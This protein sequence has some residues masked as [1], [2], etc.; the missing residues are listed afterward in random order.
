MSFTIDIVTRTLGRAALASC[1]GL[2][3]DAAMAQSVQGTAAYRERIA[4]PPAAVFEAAVEDV[5][6]ADAP[7]ETIAR[8][9]IMS[10]G[11]PPI[12][13]TITYDP[14]R[15]LPGQRYVVRTGI[16]VDEKLLI[17]RGSPPTVSIMLRKVGA[18]QAP[19][20]SP[21]GTRPLEGTYWRAIELTGKPTPTP[22]S[23]REAHLVF[24]AGGRVSGSDGC[25]RMTGSYERTGDVVMFGQMVG[26]QMACIN[27]GDIEGAFRDALK[28]ATRLTVVGDRLELFDGTG[29]RVAAFTAGAQAAVQPT[30]PG[31]AGL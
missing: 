7:A 6:R 10:P 4:L 22:E 11:N 24:Q 2:G 13:F 21:A 30:S 19:P 16:L 17:A 27:T 25:N 3:V 31:L 18:G 1:L 8:T 26:T 5:S 29:K 28:S 20:P 12:A 15:I 14:P 23:N 9:R